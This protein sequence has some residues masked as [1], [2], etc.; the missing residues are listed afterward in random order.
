VV[1]RERPAHV[2][3]R[4][5]TVFVDVEDVS[6]AALLAIAQALCDAGIESGL[7]DWTIGPFR[8]DDFDPPK[9]YGRISA[10]GVSRDGAARLRT[11]AD[12]AATVLREAGFRVVAS[13]ELECVSGVA[14]DVVRTARRAR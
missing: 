14:D 6:D 1:Q 12:V 7:H 8:L 13:A 10:D 9:F 3:V 4:R 2:T 5:G 11:A